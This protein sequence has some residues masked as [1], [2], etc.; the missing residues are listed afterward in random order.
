MTHDIQKAEYYTLTVPGQ[1]AEGFKLLS[2]FAGV[3]V[4]LRAFKAVPA[5]P[6]YTQF[7]L[8]PDDGSKMTA[9]A[10][11]A[12]LTLAGPYSALLIQG[13]DE[14]GALAD[15][16]ERLAQA[17]IQVDESSG[18]ANIKGRYGVVLYLKPEDGNR[19]LAALKLEVPQ[20]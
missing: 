4:N 11:K 18:I 13:D 9:G 7:T 2:V 19:A 8:F 5:E 1:V 6:G 17:N 14:A 12:G 20:A 16:Y 3:G 10:Q 15:I